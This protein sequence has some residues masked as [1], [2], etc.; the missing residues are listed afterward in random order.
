M[1][2]VKNELGR[3]A[4]ILHTKKYHEGGFMGYNGKEVVEVT[5][6]IEESE[7]DGAM[8][9][10]AKRSLPGDSGR[11][12]AAGSKLDVVSKAAPLPN[13]VLSQYKTNGTETGVRMAEAPIAAPAFQ[14]LIPP[15]SASLR[16]NSPAV[17]VLT[18]ETIDEATHANIAISNRQK[19]DEDVTPANNT[20]PVMIASD[21]EAA[22]K[23]QKLEA[24]LAQMKTLLTQVMS[25]D[26]PQDEVSLQEALRRQE[27]DEEILKDMAA[28]TAAGDMLMDS[29]DKR[30]PA[31]LA[32]YLE[33]KMNFAEGIKLNKHGV[34]IVSLIGATGVGKT[35]T[36]AKIAAR[37]VLEKNIRVALITADTYR[38]SAVEQLKTYSD[39]IGLPLEIV[40]SPDELKVAIH[41]HRDKD[42]ILIDTAGRSQHNEYQMKEL[43]DF[44]AVDSRIERHLVMSATTK[45]RD[46]ADILQKFSVCDPGRV[47]FTKTDETS[48]LGMIVNLLADKDIAL[49]FMTNGQ[50]VPDDI[51]PASADKLAALLLRE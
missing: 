21:S 27:V 38:I 10:R 26:Q 35:T 49:S 47:I 15:D 34:R 13:N 29:L 51:V 42:L 28:K 48:S 36:L 16:S 43:Q 4:V 11:Q 12:K 44:L 6:A 7:S 14:P 46:V 40:Y 41:K 18:T 19:E 30:A 39:I 23:I 17:K 25:K 50:S 24:E 45:M 20:Q 8:K 37:F 31:V 9:A 22:E 32:G 2:Q 1:E 33:N 3:D 5:A